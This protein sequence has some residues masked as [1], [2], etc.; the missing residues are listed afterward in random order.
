[1]SIANQGTSKG[2]HDQRGVKATYTAPGHVS[3][4]HQGTIEE[5]HTRPVEFD[6]GVDNGGER[7]ERKV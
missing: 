3:K 1:M 2:N 7:G 5:A 4:V 6:S